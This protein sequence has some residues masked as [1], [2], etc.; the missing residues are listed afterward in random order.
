MTL[1][2][3]KVVMYLFG[4]LE[5]DNESCHRSHFELQGPETI[6]KPSKPFQ[7]HPKE[8]AMFGAPYFSSGTTASRAPASL[9]IP[10]TSTSPPLWQAKHWQWAVLPAAV[11]YPKRSRLP[12]RPRP[13]GWVQAVG[14][15]VQE[16]SAKKQKEHRSW[17]FAYVCVLKAEIQ[18]VLLCLDLWWF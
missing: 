11:C 15:G 14:F 6:Q 13:A 5:L 8:S 17:V 2:T 10:G 1:L 16:A 12:S 3:T 9:T 7:K 4:S 18:Q